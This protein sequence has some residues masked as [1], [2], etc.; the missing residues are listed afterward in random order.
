MNFLHHYRPS[1]LKIQA[2][3]FISDRQGLQGQERRSFYT[4]QDYEAWKESRRHVAGPLASRA[5]A[6]DPQV[7]QGS[8]NLEREGGEG[9]L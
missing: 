2:Q 5:S 8:R 3:Q 4:L 6:V 9:V 7:L 1:L